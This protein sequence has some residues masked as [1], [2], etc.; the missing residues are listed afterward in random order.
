MFAAVYLSFIVSEFI[1]FGDLDETYSVAAR[2]VAVGLLGVIVLSCM[3]HEITFDSFSPWIGV[4]AILYAILALIEAYVEQTNRIGLGINSIPTAM[5]SVQLMFWCGCAALVRNKV[6]AVVLLGAVCAFWVVYLT[7]SRMPVAV[8]IYLLVIWVLFTKQAA[9]TRILAVLGCV[10]IVPV[11]GILVPGVSTGIFDRFAAVDLGVMT[12]VASE[13]PSVKVA[14]SASGMHRAWIWKAGF[15]LILQQPWFGWGRGMGVTDQALMAV[16]APDVV[17]AHP[18]FHN[19][20][21]DI[22]VRFGV[23]AAV[24]LV[25][26]YAGLFGTART[27]YQL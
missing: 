4:V 11:L 15:D 7:G 8:S 14:S 21:I 23:P 16:Q 20:L 27:R 2:Y 26:S 6:P 5:I 10:L 24:L 9:R 17:R 12:E 22:S 19:E 3:R 1:T 13:A 25:L 18:H